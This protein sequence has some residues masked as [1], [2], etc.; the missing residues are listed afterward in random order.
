[1]KIGI[2]TQPLHDNYGGLLQAYA[3]KEVLKE[4]GH[5]VIIINRKSKVSKRW[6]KYASFA[7]SILIDRKLS[8]NIFMKQSFLDEISKQTIKFRDE[9]IPELSGEIRNQKGMKRL[10]SMG[11]DAYIVGSDQCWRPKYSP[12]I[13]N[14]FLDFTE[15]DMHVKRISY[16]ASFGVSHWEFK[17]NDTAACKDL[18]QM[19]D[20]V[21]VREDSAIKLISDNLGRMDALHVIDPTMLLRPE[22]YA[23]IV[24]QEQISSS[25]GNL[26]V[27]VL[28]KT[29]E[30]EHIIHLVADKLNLKVFEVLPHTRLKEKKVTKDNICNFVY[31]SPAIW[32]RGFQDAQFVLT[33]SF[34]GTVFSILHNIPFVAFGNVQRGMSRFKS[35]LT[36]FGL[37]DRLIT[38]FASFDADQL[39]AKKID[40]ASVNNILEVERKKAVRFL[41]ENLFLG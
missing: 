12:A 35:L 17:D 3:L 18:I 33:D 4:L 24:E 11:F 26:K 29:A 32:L 6:R 2:L 38:D 16:A 15:N 10:N 34:H 8:P 31:P 22:Q 5:E 9:Y 21:S 19:F 30:K 7:K 37:Q 39:I 23:E 36:M 40:W 14:Y 27:Y 1:M 41:K 20:A 28:D 13:R 25:A